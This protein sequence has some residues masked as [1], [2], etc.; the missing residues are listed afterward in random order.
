MIE[1]VEKEALLP[2][3]GIAV[4][5]GRTLREVEAMLETAEAGLKKVEEEKDEVIPRTK[6]RET[7]ILS[8]WTVWK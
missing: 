6:V 3:A 2:A 8:V 4:V 1:V 7:A 5:G